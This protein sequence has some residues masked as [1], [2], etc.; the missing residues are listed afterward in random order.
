MRNLLQVIAEMAELFNY[1]IHSVA[2]LSF[3]LKKGGTVRLHLSKLLIAMSCVLVTEFYLF[4][5]QI[6]MNASLLLV[7]MVPPV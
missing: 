7:D 3:A 5:V 4:S 1:E 6:L 2:T